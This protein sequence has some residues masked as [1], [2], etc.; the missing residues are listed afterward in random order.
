MQMEFDAFRFNATIS[1]CKRGEQWQQDLGMQTK[2][3][4]QQA[5]LDAINFNAAISA[6]EKDERWQ[7]CLDAQAGLQPRRRGSMRSLPL[8]LSALARRVHGGDWACWRFCSSSSG[9]RT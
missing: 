4:Q 9:S 3:Q 6:C 1:A 7:Q 8:Q 2:M 5:E